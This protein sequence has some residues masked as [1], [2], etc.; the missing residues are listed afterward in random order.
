MLSRQQILFC[1]CGPAASGKSTICRTLCRGELEGLMLSVSTTTRAP[2]GSEKEAQEYFFVS[3]EEFVKR[4]DSGQ[5]IEH[6]RFGSALYG[7]ERRNIESAQ[8][9]GCDLLLDIDVQGVRQL[10]ANFPGQVVVIFVFPPS[11]EELKERFRSR[12]TEGEARIAERLEIAKSEIAVLAQPDFSDFLL[13]NDSLSSA[14]ER[15]KGIIVAERQ[16][17]SRIDQLSLSKLLN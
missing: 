1:F 7:T 4:V 8:A 17:L 15:A 13:V 16:R 5:F 3:E 12:G 9:G 11:L 10:K 6:A 2:R 14:V